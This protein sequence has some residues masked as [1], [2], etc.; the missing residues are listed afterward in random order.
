MFRR[1]VPLSWKGRL[2]E[3]ILPRKGFSRLYSYMA[4]RV[5]R[6]PGTPYSLAAGLPAGSGIL[7]PVNRFSSGAGSCIGLSDAR[8]YYCIMGRNDY[9]QSVDISI[10][11]YPASQGWQLSDRH[12]W[13]AKLVFC[14]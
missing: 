13:F 6:M 3:V 5:L 12:V 8:K 1:R 10:Y 14:R 9:W 4:Q 7:Y 11:F 2:R